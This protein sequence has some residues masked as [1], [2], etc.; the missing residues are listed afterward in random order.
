MDGDTDLGGPV[1]HFPVT[2]CTVILATGSPDPVVRQQAFGSLVAGYWKPVYKYIRL[3]RRSSNDDA[4]DLTQAFFL[5]ALQKGFFQ[6]YDPT[7][8]RFRTYL[9]VCVDGFVGKHVR[10]AHRL[11]RGGE[12]PVLS[13]DFAQAERELG[14]HIPQGGGDVDE[15][16]HREWVRSLLGLAVED[17]RQ[18]CEQAGKRIHFTL[19]ERYDLEAPDRQERLSYA[20]L[21]REFGV[22]ITQVTNHLAFARRRFRTHLLDR[23]RATTG[24]DEEFRDEAR[25]LLG[26]DVP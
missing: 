4:K 14:L 17:L 21:S 26:G 7:Q 8:S 1:H 5:E 22:P 3:H 15:F 19:F 9:R 18:E 25:H 12:T 20:E 23:L 6:Q 24:S 11:K 10:A 13:L 2:R 16:F